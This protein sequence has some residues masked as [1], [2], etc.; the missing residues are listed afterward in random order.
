MPAIIIAVIAMA[1]TILLA[2][3]GSFVGSEAVT[4]GQ[5]EAEVARSLNGLAQ[6]HSALTQYRAD[7]GENA[8]TIEDL[9]PSYLSSVP[10][11]WTAKVPSQEAFQS[12]QLLQGDEA[13][14]L[15][16]CNKVNARL[17]LPSP[18]PKCSDIDPNFMG[19]CVAADAP[20]AQ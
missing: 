9:M 16:S 19:C 1:L 12:S 20:P 18:P 14:Q 6:I 13:Q 8:T 11:G 3:M 15:D 5:Q 4:K 7:Q 2:T 10:Y 17:S